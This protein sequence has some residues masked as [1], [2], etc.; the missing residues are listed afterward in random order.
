MDSAG[1]VELLQL[2]GFQAA[3][4]Y[5]LKHSSYQWVWVQHAGM[6]GYT[7]HFLSLKVWKC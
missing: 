6:Q 4:A 5:V 3:W 2:A 7:G 1:P